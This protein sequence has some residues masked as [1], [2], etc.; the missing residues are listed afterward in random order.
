MFFGWF[1]KKRMSMS[2]KDLLV[3]QIAELEKK[4]QQ[5]Q[6]DKQTL[7]TQLQR[8]K[9][10]EFEESEREVSEQTLLKG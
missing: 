7:E 4:I 1:D 9:V 3:S 8:L 10:A 2:Y 5:A 6:G